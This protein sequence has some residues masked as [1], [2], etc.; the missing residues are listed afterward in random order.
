MVSILI[1]SDHDFSDIYFLYY[2]IVDR[3]LLRLSLHDRFH[4][5]NVEDLAIAAVNYHSSLYNISY[6]TI[7][8]CS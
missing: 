7:A 2:C 5:S 8:M 1:P 6:Y 3:K 4:E